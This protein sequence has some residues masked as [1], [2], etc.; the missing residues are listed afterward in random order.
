VAVRDLHQRMDLRSA[1]YSLI[2]FC[3]DPAREEYVN[4]A[5]AFE[6]P[7]Y[8]YVGVKVLPHMDSLIRCVSPQQDP[9][10]IRLITRD[11]VA[12]YETP[13]PEI[14]QY[15]E[16][17]RPQADRLLQLAR[18]LTHQHGSYWRVTAPRASLLIG[19]QNV[20]SELETLYNRLV[21]RERRDVVERRDKT[22]VKDRTITKLHQRRVQLIES[23]EVKGDRFPRIPF[24][25]VHRNGQNTYLQFLSFD[26][27]REPTPKELAA[28]LYYVQDFRRAHGE[29]T[30]A[31]AAVVA[32]PSYD[33][34]LPAFR[35]QV[36]ILA[37]EGVPAFGTSESDYDALAHGLTNPNLLQEVATLP[38]SYL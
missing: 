16:P 10:L 32:P 28:F 7:G 1:F 5:I 8:K 30:A 24:D 27:L 15:V 17:E 18:E 35:E 4:I 21:A 12:R 25:A 11:I 31:V 6:A 3:P 2:Q 14:S 29:D 13:P 33:S 23:P 34:F 20:T 38:V 26:R 9:T 37:Q 22:W 19:N 36:K